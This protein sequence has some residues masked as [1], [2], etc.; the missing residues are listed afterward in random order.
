MVRL[1][2][3]SGGSSEGGRGPHA[4]PVPRAALPLALVCACWDGRKGASEMS[5]L[6]SRCAEGL[7]K[8]GWYLHTCRKSLGYSAY[9]PDTEG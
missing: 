3:G 6:D 1:A 5:M 9:L 8:G 2:L 7:G 4:I